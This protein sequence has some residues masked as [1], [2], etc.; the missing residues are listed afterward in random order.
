[1]N[2]LGNLSSHLLQ[3]FLDD[4]LRSDCL[5][6]IAIYVIGT[7]LRGVRRSLKLVMKRVDSHEVRLVELERMEEK[8]H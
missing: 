7:E 1:M 6:L 4:S 2:L 3:L 5:K 8:T